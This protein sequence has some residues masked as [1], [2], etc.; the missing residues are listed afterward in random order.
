MTKGRSEE[1]PFFVASEVLQADFFFVTRFFLLAVLRRIGFLFTVAFF[2]L[3]AFFFADGR[4]LGFFAP[5]AC[6]FAAS[7]PVTPF[8]RNSRS[9]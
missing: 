9:F 2:L 4:F 1:R 7:M 5:N 3:A 6:S 8:S